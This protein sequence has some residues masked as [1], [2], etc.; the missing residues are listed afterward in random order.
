MID[1]PVNYVYMHFMTQRDIPDL[2]QTLLDTCLCHNVRMA[3][4]VVSRVVEPGTKHR[5]GLGGPEVEDQVVQP[6]DAA[7]T[8]Q[9]GDAVQRE[10]FP[11]VGHLVQGVAGEHRIRR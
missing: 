3:S 9:P 8:Q 2:A 5:L 11:E 7:G 6:Q 4:R 10:R 1:L